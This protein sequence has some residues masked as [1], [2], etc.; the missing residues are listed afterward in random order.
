MFSSILGL[1]PLHVRSRSCFSHDNWKRFQIL[2]NIPVRKGN[3]LIS[4]W[5]WESV[6][7]VKKWFLFTR[8]HSNIHLIINNS[9]E[10]FAHLANKPQGQEASSTRWVQGL[11]L[12]P[13]L[14]M[15]CSGK[16]LNLWALVSS[17]SQVML[18]GENL[19]ANAGDLTDTSSISGLGRS[20]R[21]GNGNP[22]Q[23]SCL[24]NGQRSLV[25]YSP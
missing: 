24:E 16:F 5:P 14:A 9:F 15:P 25:G 3:T 6:P 17:G 23:S 20:P 12:T 1:F 7:K 2:P 10:L 22:L 18:V 8:T 11:C 21:G 4:R 13:R 19:P